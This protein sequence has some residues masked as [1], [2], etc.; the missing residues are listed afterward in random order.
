[1]AK[2]VTLSLQPCHNRTPPDRSADRRRRALTEQALCC[3]S[4]MESIMSDP[5]HDRRA[6]ASRCGGCRGGTNRLAQE[7]SPYL[8]QHKDNPVA[9]WP[10][11]P[12]GAWPRPSAPTSRSCSRS[13][14]PPAIGAMSWRMKASRT[15]PTA[16]GDERAVRQHQSRPRGASRHRPDLHERAASSGRAG[17]LAAD[18][19]SHARRRAV[20]GRHLFSENLAIWPAGLCRCA[21]GSVAA[22][23][24]RARQDRAEPRCA[25]G[26]ACGESAR[27][28]AAS[29]SAVRSSTIS[30]CRSR[31]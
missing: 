16:R 18:H 6:E 27:G 14:M 23:S 19:V 21:A 7:T 9:W 28:A 10:W 15:T 26:A 29:M 17:R 13:A 1:M 5:S 30:R 3:N 12:A 25:D 24:R 22:V 8:L 11:G 4:V 31:A 20:L 2:I